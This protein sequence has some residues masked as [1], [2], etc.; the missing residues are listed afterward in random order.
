MKDDKDDFEF[1]EEIPKRTSGK[2]GYVDPER[3][4]LADICR[5]NPGKWLKVPERFYSHLSRGALDFASVVRSGK[6]PAFLPKGSFAARS[7]G[8]IAYIMYTG[9]GESE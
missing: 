1:V 9:D 6:S 7:R 5:A 2:Y 8:G 4:K 3:L